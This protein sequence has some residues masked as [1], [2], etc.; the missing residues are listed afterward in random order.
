LAALP[1]LF[2]RGRHLPRLLISINAAWNVVNFR[3]ALV[4]ALVADG[5]EVAAAVV[6]DGAMPGIAALGAR[7]IAL[8]MA[9][10]SVSPFRD[11]ALFVRYVRLMRRER[12]D[13]YLGWTIKPNT[14]GATAAALCGIPTIAN[15]SGLGTAFIRSNWLTWVARRLYPVGLRRASTVFF[16]ND[17]DRALFLADGLVRADQCALLPG[18]GID[19]DWFDPR[20]FAQAAVDDRDFRFLFVGRLIRDKGVHEYVA[21]ARIVRATHP[22]ARFQIL[23]FL[24]A[25]NRTAIDRSTLNDWVAEGIV[26][27][28]GTAADVRPAIAQA[29]CIVLPSYREGLSRVLL[30]AAAMATPAIASDVP[31]C[32]DV[33]V[34]GVTGLLC[35]VRDAEDLAAQMTAMLALTPAARTA[36]G[37]AARADVIA[38]FSEQVVIDRYRI[39]I[40]RA[41]SR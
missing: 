20:A 7:P 5:H 39:A 37:A 36:M 24:D 4:R 25:D 30:E 13:V 8:T 2:L 35:R 17:D 1:I 27:Y 16:Q 22:E 6:D 40:A 12:P 32:R 26:E 41:L 21:A 31:G 3:A 10:R 15:I 9:S 28:L 23:G 33:V 34:A 11:L 38:R 18:S 19:P 14:Y 29:D